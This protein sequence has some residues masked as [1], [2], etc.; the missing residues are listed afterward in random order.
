[1]DIALGYKNIADK[2]NISVKS[3]LDKDYPYNWKMLSGMPKV[4]YFKGSYD[5]I[6]RMTLNGSCAVVGSRNASKYSV[7]YLGIKVSL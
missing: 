5:I 4:F 2:E 6:T 7:V 3:C 1:M